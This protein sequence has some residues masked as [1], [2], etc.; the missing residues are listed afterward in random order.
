MFDIRN[1]TDEAAAAVTSGAPYKVT[2]I[3]AEPY[4]AEVVEWHRSP[5]DY[6]LRASALGWQVEQALYYG[7]YS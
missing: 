1:L 2:F 3:T 5:E 4:E 6:R 7:Y